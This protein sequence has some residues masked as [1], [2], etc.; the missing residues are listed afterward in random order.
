MQ[1]H[2]GPETFLFWDTST[3]IL[4]VVSIERFPIGNVLVSVA[5]VCVGI[6]VISYDFGRRKG[7][8]C[9][10]PRWFVPPFRWGRGKEWL[11]IS[12]FRMKNTNEGCANVHLIPGEARGNLAERLFAV[13]NTQFLY[14]VLD[15]SLFSG[16]PRQGICCLSITSQFMLD[17]LLGF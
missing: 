8:K 6:I 9:V 5:F 11:H 15:F 14:F 12:A 4:Y 13:R 7:R 2:V 10:W 17:S 16:K 1:I 3:S